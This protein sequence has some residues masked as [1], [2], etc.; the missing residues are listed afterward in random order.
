[1]P[2]ELAKDLRDELIALA[3]ATALKALMF[4]PFECGYYSA[5]TRINQHRVECKQSMR[6][7]R[8]GCESY[9]TTWYLNDKRVGLNRLIH[10]LNQG[11]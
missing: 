1:M 5:F 10:E 3:D 11:T 4:G 6:M 2:I 7:T 8:S 9:V